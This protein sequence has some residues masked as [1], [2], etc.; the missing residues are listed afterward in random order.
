M[1][2]ASARQPTN[3]SAQINPPQDASNAKEPGMKAKNIIPGALRIRDEIDAS[4]TV[5]F[6]LRSRLDIARTYDILNGNNELQVKVADYLF[7]AAQEAYHYFG[8]EKMPKLKRLLTCLLFHRFSLAYWV[9]WTYK[10]GDRPTAKGDLEKTFV[11]RDQQFKPPNEVLKTKFKI[12][13]TNFE[14]PFKTPYVTAW[15]RCLDAGIGDQSMLVI[16]Y[17]L[18]V[19]LV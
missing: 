17:I 5:R 14:L 13:V 12:N 3:K 10:G 19:H 11:E 6:P 4:S 15:R 9:T 7:Q 18:F 2:A 8:K 16:H 1:P